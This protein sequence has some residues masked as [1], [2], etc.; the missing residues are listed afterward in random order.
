MRLLLVNPRFN[1]SF[2]SFKWAMD[3]MLAGKRAMNPPLGLATLAA[4]C[5]PDWQVEIVDENIESLPLAP[6]ADIIGIGG[7]GVQAPRQK[8][9]LRFY[10]AKGYYVVAGGSY[11]SLCP[12]FYDGIADSVICGEAEY[13]WPQFCRDYRHGAARRLYAETGTVSMADSPAPRFDLLKLEKYSGVTVQ[14]SRGC[15]YRC[16]FCDIIVM[17]G[18]KPRW[19]SPAQIGLEL[20]A[21]RQ[22]NV[23]DVFFVDDNFIGN[24]KAAGSLLEYLKDYQERHGYRFIFGTE[25]SLNV[26]QDD[27]LLRLFREAHFAWVFIGIES[28]D[29][30]SLKET[31]KSQNLRHD[32]L[33]SV[34]RIY[35]RGIDVLAGF[36]IGFDNDTLATFDRQ[37]RFIVDSGIQAAMI[38][39]LTALPRTPLYQRLEK[40]G[41]LI[42]QAENTDNT[43]PGTNILPQRMD[44][45]AMVASYQDLYRRLLEDR[46]IAD[47]IRN[48][49]RYL[50]DPVR[51]SQYRLTEGLAIL[52]RL[53]ASGILPGGGSRL[54]HFLRSLPL[55]SPRLLPQAITDWIV[56]LAMRDYV[57]RR[58]GIALR[59]RQAT[60]SRLFES[61]QAALADYL[62]SGRVTVALKDGLAGGP[63]LSVSLGGWLDRRF[64]SRIAGYLEKLLKRTSSTVTLRIEMAHEA[65]LS[66]LNRLL[67]RL[68]P[69]GDRI[70]IRFDARL[71]ELVRVDSSV[72][73]LILD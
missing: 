40:E 9:L 20:D 55:A 45:D 8:E 14:F 21:L 23:R 39:L 66:H 7:M 13:V 56:G 61:L 42:A 4:L 47:R 19:K 72:F 26:A 63:N 30:D 48:K 33:D 16:E 10:R 1:E 58:F 24:R 36:I 15:P 5:P 57:E 17:F 52:G 51:Q 70:F 38:G 73:H 43:R 60:A 71:R 3:R 53:M 34:R 67:Q 25:V 50:R 18:R 65:E 62:R 59:A 12:E 64:F 2:W 46:Q 35:A 6:Q 29:V 41:R 31:K 69:Y 37:Y 68:A 27:A 32:I 54:F 11:A 28:P 49:L 44:Y 22:R